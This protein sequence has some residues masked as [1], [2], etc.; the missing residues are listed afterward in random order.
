ML[1]A[2]GG[3]VSNALN[4]DS[5]LDL[6]DNDGELVGGSGSEKGDAL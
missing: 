1:D 5:D 6:D 4:E 3:R 2:K